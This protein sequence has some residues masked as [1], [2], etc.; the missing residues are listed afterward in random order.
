MTLK[1]IEE[2]KQEMMRLYRA[3]NQEKA[4][5]A[6]AS[7]EAVQTPPSGRPEPTQPLTPPIVNEQMPDERGGLLVWVTTLRNLYAVPNALVTVRD[8]QTGEVIDTATTDIS[9]R[10]K[11]FVLPT[12][13]KNF[14]D[15]PTA[16][17]RP[18]SLYNVNVKADGYNEQNFLNVPVFPTITSIQPVDMI[19][20]SASN[21]TGEVG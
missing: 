3:S 15:D 6:V 9:G 1:S 10:T 2:Y 13:P 7:P 19:L 20:N 11:I 4:V 21:N 12:P 14:S 17:Q 5:P 8:D 16:T 18:Y